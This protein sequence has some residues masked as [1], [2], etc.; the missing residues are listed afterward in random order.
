MV[1][2]GKTMTQ[3]KKVM[4]IGDLHIP[5]HHKDS[6]AFLR[7]L[8]KKYKGF[9]LVVNIGDELDQHAISM[10]D[11]DP[12]LPSAG[13]ELKLAKKHVKDL[14]KIF[15]DMTLVDSNHS[16]LVYRR[17][18][19]YGLPKAYLKHYNEFLGVSPTR[20]KWVQDLTITLND[21]S[22]CFFTHGMSANVLQI[23]QRYGMNTV[24]GHYHS[25]SSIQY[26]SNP[27]KLVWG[28]Q[29]GCLT[30]QDSLAFS[31]SRLFKDRFIMSS[32]VIVDGQP[33]IH[34]MVIKDGKWIGK[35][36]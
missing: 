18:L 21:G 32:L 3:Y 19:K 24:Q 25:K 30:N 1:I 13:D 36:V 12:D 27:D 26:Y 33:R 28:A 14:E 15:P 4:V 2:K 31:Y 17:A 29:T 20:W 10:H 11:S 9:D 23:A 5:Y 6:F 16:S 22:R 7:A 8:K 34:P 35:I